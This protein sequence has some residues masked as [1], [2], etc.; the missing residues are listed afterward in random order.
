MAYR[1]RSVS[2]WALVGIGLIDGVQI[3]ANADFGCTHLRDHRANGSMCS[4][5]CVEGRLPGLNSEPEEFSSVLGRLPRRLPLGFH[6]L[7][8]NGFAG[9]ISDRRCSGSGG[10]SAARRE[11][12]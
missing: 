11:Y 5:M 4:A 10:G 2:T 1:L 6:Y 9:A 3:C 12:L 8:N 7:A